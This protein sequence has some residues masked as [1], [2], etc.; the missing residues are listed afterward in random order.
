LLEPDTQ[1]RY[2]FPAQRISRAP[3]AEG[4]AAEQPVY[5]LRL[6]ML[7]CRG[8]DGGK[9][10]RMNRYR[11]GQQPIDFSLA[12][13]A[14][15]AV[16]AQFRGRA[17]D[18]LRGDVEPEAGALEGRF[19]VARVG[20]EGLALSVEQ[21]G[22]ARLRYGEQGPHQAHPCHLAE[23]GHAGETVDAAASP[24]TD[25]IGLGLVLAVMRGQEMEAALGAAPLREQIVARR[26]RRFLDSGRGLR[27]G[28][29]QHMMF[30]AAS[31][32]P[33]ADR[34]R[35]VG[36]FRP[37]TVIDGQSRQSAAALARPAIGQDRQRETVGTAGQRDGNEGMP[38]EP[39]DSVECRSQL[40][41][42]QRRRRCRDGVDPGQQP[43]RFFS[44]E[45]RSLIAAPGA[46]KS[47]SSWVS[48]MQAF[49]F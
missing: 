28:P 20:Q 49:C 31:R 26:T 7:D 30:D 6:G 18:I 21:R 23:G 1:A 48:A 34:L 37:Q 38:L 17:L 46:G 3:D 11:P 29:R 42:T 36:A 41:Q 43:R 4:G 22:K 9:A 5:K 40:R 33:A 44:V 32:H 8:I 27:V 10:R 13:D 39:A 19:A 24:P 35:F 25:Q 47:W 14:L 45:A 16:V 12:R 2:A 15:A